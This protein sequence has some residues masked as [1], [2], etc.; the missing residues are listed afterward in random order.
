LTTI[1][2]GHRPTW[3]LGLYLYRAGTALP[4]T[5]SLIRSNNLVTENSLPAIEFMAFIGF[6][7]WLFLRKG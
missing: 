2:S 3:E 5:A 7:I 1:T 4:T 6:A